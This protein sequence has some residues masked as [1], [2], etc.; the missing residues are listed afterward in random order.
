M[1]KNFSRPSKV[2]NALYTKIFVK[3]MVIKTTIAKRSSLKKSGQIMFFFVVKKTILYGVYSIYLHPWVEPGLLVDLI[4][5][6]KLQ[7]FSPGDYVCRKGDVGRE[8]YII[9]V[10][11]SRLTLSNH[12]TISLFVSMP[13]PILLSNRKA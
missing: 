1:F 11:T 9:K 4:L 5:K 7:V 2:T 10:T 6:L 8:M 13:P 3:I 12:T